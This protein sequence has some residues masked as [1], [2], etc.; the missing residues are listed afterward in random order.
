[1]FGINLKKLRKI[2]GLTQE[3]LA[4]DLSVSRQ[5][6]SMW[7]RG[8]RTPKVGVLTKIVSIFGIS[9][10]HLL[11]LERT[12]QNHDPAAEVE[13]KEP[14]EILVVDDEKG[15]RDLLSKA[16]TGS[17]Y[18]VHTAEDGETAIMMLME[19]RKDDIDLIILDAKLPGMG[20]I[21]TLKRMKQ[22]R[23]DLPVVMISAYATHL[24]AIETRILGA[25]KC[26][27]KPFTMERLRKVIKSALPRHSNDSVKN[28]MKEL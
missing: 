2:N 13:G 18:T 6:V 26:L 3:D 11:H 24:T 14:E 17:G 23:K 27:R 8:E 25:H 16:L 1:M 28:N 4:N 22:I 5:A 21:T 19:G 7:E 12:P 20:S 10:D 9:M 15:M